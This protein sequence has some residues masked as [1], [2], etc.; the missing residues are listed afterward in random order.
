M[1][2]LI[3]ILIAFFKKL[4]TNKKQNTITAIV[5]PIETKE[6]PELHPQPYKHRKNNRKLTAARL[7]DEKN[8]KVQSI[9]I[10]ENDQKNNC[11]KFIGYKYIFHK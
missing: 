3:K 4:F 6:N 10:F 8:C 1:K 5:P 11:F 7:K 9:A 2:K